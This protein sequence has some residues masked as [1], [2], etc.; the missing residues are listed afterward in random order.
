MP[1]GGAASTGATTMRSCDGARTGRAAYVVTRY[2][3]GETV[4]NFEYFGIRSDDPNDIHPHKHPR[5]L[6]RTVC[7]P[8]GSRTTTRGPSTAGISSLRRTGASTSAI[9]CTFG[10]VRRRNQVRRAP[11]G[12][13]ETYLDKDEALQRWRASALPS[14]AISACPVPM[15]RRQRERS[16]HLVRSGAMEGELSDPASPTC[17]RTMCLGGQLVA[18]FSTKR[19]ARSSI[20]FSSTTPG[21]RAHHPCADRASRRHRT[22]VAERREPG[23]RSAPGDEAH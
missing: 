18:R 1:Q 15:D 20:K 17:V 10:A 16:Q 21:G 19:F 9:T 14:R 7:F 8:R 3:Q 23:R 5:E 2:H 4:G 6:R 22:D 13:H 11:T 12:N